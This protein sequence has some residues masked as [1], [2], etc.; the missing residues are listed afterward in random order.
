MSRWAVGAVHFP[1]PGQGG[2]SSEAG[3]IFRQCV[4]LR[5]PL[6]GRSWEFRIQMKSLC[7]LFTEPPWGPGGRELWT[8]SREVPSESSF[9]DERQ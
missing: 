8:P 3:S 2:W 6:T 7:A 4:I 5:C 9:G 1:G